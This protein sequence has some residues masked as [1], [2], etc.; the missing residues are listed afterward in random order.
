MMAGEILT[1]D[2][3]SCDQ[4]RSEWPDEYSRRA[5]VPA[6]RLVVFITNR[7]EVYFQTPAIFA[8]VKRTS[9]QVVVLD[10]RQQGLITHA[11]C[12]RR[13]RFITIVGG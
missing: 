4:L 9:L 8:L 7:V 3:R 10:L 2:R 1:L 6:R 5:G 13:T 12:F 11:K